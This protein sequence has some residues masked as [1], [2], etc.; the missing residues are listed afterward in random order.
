M[1]AGKVLDTRLQK[2]LLIIII[3]ISFM[4]FAYQN[5]I[6]QPI[7]II[8]CSYNNAPWVEQNLDSIFSQ[9][10]INFRLLYVDDC[11]GDGTAELVQAYIEKNDLQNK[12][13]LIA[14]KGRQLK[15][16]N[17]YN[18]CHSCNDQEII[19]ILDGDDWFDN[20]KVLKN[21]N[22]AYLGSDVW[23]TYGQ[24]KF[25]PTGGLAPKAQEVLSSVLEKRNF[26]QWKWVYRHPRSFYAWL[27][28]L[29]KLEDLLT[30]AV[31]GFEGLFYPDI[32]DRQMVYSMLEMAQHKI[33]FIPGISVIQN[34][35]NPLSTM[36]NSPT[37]RSQVCFR[38]IMN[39]PISY[40][41]LAS[42]IVDRLDK[43]NNVQADCIILCD[44]TPSSLAQQ[45][46]TVQTNIQN[47]GNILIIYQLNDQTTQVDWDQFMQSYKN[48]QFIEVS[49]LKEHIDAHPALLSHE[50][51]V[52]CY[53]GSN[54]NTLIDCR[55]IIQQLEQTFAYAWYGG[56]S[57]TLCK[58]NNIPFQHI[59][60]NM[61]A[62][63][64]RSDPSLKIMLQGSALTLYR[65]NDLLSLL[66]SN[67]EDIKTVINSWQAYDNKQCTI[68]LFY[69]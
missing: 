17:I 24:S 27:F 40:T 33:K 52:V 31:P 47:I 8:T 1:Q 43:L 26:R 45:I 34:I 22:Q 53:E 20:P 16:H 39:K 50:Y 44:T 30:N 14:N 11:S 32:E 3:N 48:I 54:I 18:A 49:S 7:V 42:P 57:T 9:D 25:Y 58:K 69:D 55:K 67:Q 38:E 35:R 2:L 21:I 10:Y 28:K 41:V 37:K 15:C 4:S 36:G 46:Q 51:V 13:T 64:F 68:G 66:Q 5:N 63:K 59:I 56:I 62:I 6:E 23:F 29:I 60:D 65:K 12:V 19:V 61:Y